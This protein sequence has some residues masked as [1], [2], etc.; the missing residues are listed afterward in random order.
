ME[1]F[2]YN[3]FS[4]RVLCTSIIVQL[5]TVLSTVSVY[6]KIWRACGL[7][8]CCLFFGSSFIV[9]TLSD[10]SWFLKILYLV[11]WSHW[12]LW[13]TN[14]KM[15]STQSGRMPYSFPRSSLLG[16]RARARGKYFYWNVWNYMKRKY[17]SS[18]IESLVGRSIL[19]RGTGIVTRRPLIL[20]L[21]YTPRDDRVRA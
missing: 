13:S 12:S 3:D 2:V 10:W 16:L 11:W 8:F 17:S 19:P 6:T 5:C 14:Y 9:W 18:V 15:F 20:Q 7:W 1:L 21:V 4:Y